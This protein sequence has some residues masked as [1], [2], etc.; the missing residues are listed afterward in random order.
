MGNPARIALVGAAIPL[1]ALSTAGCT[2]AA[3]GTNPGGRAAA[4]PSQV[5]P[6]PAGS[7]GA[8]AIPVGAG[9]KAAYLAQAQPAPGSCHY[10]YTAD[11]QPLPDTACT[12][13]A[14]SPAVTQ[15]NINDTICKPGGYTSAIRPPSNITGKEKADNAKSYGYSGPAGDAEYDHLISLQLGGDPNDPRNLWVEPPSPDHVAGKGPNNPKDSVETHLHTAICK[16]QTTLAAAQQAIVT[17]WTTAEA[18]LGIK[19]AGMATPDASTDGD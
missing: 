1:L 10:R 3:K 18:K 14:T 17:D 13:G 16:G 7:A 19:P 2:P 6:A 8:V 11:K 9:P 4:S 5:A 12:P 15:A